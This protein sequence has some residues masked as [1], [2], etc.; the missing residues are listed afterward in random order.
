MVKIPH[1]G[2]QYFA[3]AQAFESN[4]K[5]GPNMPPK[6]K[7]AFLIP[8]SSDGQKWSVFVWNAKLCFI[9]VDLWWLF[10]TQRSL[11]ASASLNLQLIIKN[12]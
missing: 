4:A 10:G 3:T 11:Q 1:N 12:F 2:P 6:A 5:T 7:T 9:Q 8:R